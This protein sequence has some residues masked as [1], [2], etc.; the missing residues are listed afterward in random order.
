MPFFS[1]GGREHHRKTPPAQGGKEGSL[2]LLLTKTLPFPSGV[3]CQIRGISFEWFLRL[4]ELDNGPRI[5]VPEI[6]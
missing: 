5:L 3:P 1:D 4:V 6:Q 2:R